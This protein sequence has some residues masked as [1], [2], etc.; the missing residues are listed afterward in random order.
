M[1]LLERC[2]PPCPVPPRRT[3]HAV[4]STTHLARGRRTLHYGRRG[5]RLQLYSSVSRCLCFKLR[6]CPLHL[7]K[8]G[9]IIVR[10]GRELLHSGFCF[11][12]PDPRRASPP[13]AM[14]LTALPVRTSRRNRNPERAEQSNNPEP[15]QFG[16]PIKPAINNNC[17]AITTNFGMLTIQKLGLI[18]RCH[19][20]LFR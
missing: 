6:Q 2:R 12:L 4:L 5:Q 16:L 18:L 7:V 3:S 1:L 14:I 9:G 10:A 11:G 8:Y 17:H 20:S 13:C 15:R 19:R